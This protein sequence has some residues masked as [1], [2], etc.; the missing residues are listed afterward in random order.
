MR[1]SPPLPAPFPSRPDVV[2]WWARLHP[3]RTAL[4][5]RRR[6]ERLTY[7]ELD[8]ASERW[9]RLLRAQ[10]VAPGDRVALLAGN[11][12]EAVALFGGCLRTGA[13]LVPLNW[14]LAAP[15]LAPVLADAA[16]QLLVG[17][18]RLRALAERAAALGGAAV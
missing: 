4:V 6:D 18:G 15:E 13:V 17:E 2:S 16:A 12:A 11:R 10:G 8:A 3:A 1:P 5:D 9:A 14:R 7:A